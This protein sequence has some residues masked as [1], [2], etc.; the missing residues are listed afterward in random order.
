VILDSS[1]PPRIGDLLMHDYAVG[2]IRDK[3]ISA[4]VY[5][6]SCTSAK[7]SITRIATASTSA[8]RVDGGNE[9]PI[10]VG[11]PPIR[12]P[13]LRATHRLIHRFF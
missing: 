2:G 12:S 10:P 11:Q 3:P 8:D 13:A 4:F 6:V 7:R 5:A 1:V 9:P